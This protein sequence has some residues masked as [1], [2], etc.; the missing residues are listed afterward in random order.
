[1]RKML[2]VMVVFALAFN[3]L[4]ADNVRKNKTEPAPS[5]TTPQNIENNSRTEDWILYMIDSYGDGW[6]GASVDLL[7]NGTVVLDDQSV[8]GSEGTVYFSVDEGDIIETVWTSGSYDNEC[9]YGI[10]NHYG[11]LQASAGTEDNPTYEIYLIA[12]FPVL[13]FF[14]EYAEGTSNNKYLEIYNN[15][16]ADLDLSAYSLSSCSNGCDETGE[17]DYPDNVTFDA[18]TIVAAGDVYVVHH[19]DADA[20]IT[21]E[22]DQTHQYLSN[23]DDA[24]ALTLAGA[25]ADVYTIVDII[26]DMGDDPGAGWPVA[27]VDDG[28]KEHTLVRKGSVVHGNDGD[29][30]SSAGVT[31]DGSEWIVLEQNDWTNLGSHT[32]DGDG[33]CTDTEY[34]VTVDGGTYQSEVGWE[35]VNTSLEV[36]ASGGAPIVVGDGVTACL[37]DGSYG[38]LM[39]DSYGDGWNGNIIQLWTLDADGNPVEQFSGT[40]ESGDYGVGQFN[41]GDGPFDVLVGCTDPT[42]S[43]TDADAIW[44]DGS[45]SY[46]GTDCST[47]L[48]AAVGSN[49]ASG[50]PMWY[51]YTA[52]MSGVATVSSVGGGVDTQVYG[53]SGTCDALEQ[54]GFGDDEGGSPE[55]SSIMSFVIAEGT[56][57]YINWTDYWSSDGFVW[58]LEEAGIPTTPENL[59][60]LG[61][62][63][64][65]YLEFSPFNPANLTQ[66]AMASG[67]D[68][69]LS[70]E[71]HVQM[72]ADKVAASKVE[73]SNAWQGKTLE[74]VQDHVATLDL[75]Q[76]R[77]TETYITL[78]DSYGDGHDGD[79]YLM[80]ED[81]DGTADITF[82]ET[83]Y[84]IVETMAGGWT[85]YESAYGPFTL[86]D[87]LYYVA[88]SPDASYLGEQSYIATDAAGV[89]LGA[90]EYG[91]GDPLCFEAGDSGVECPAAAI[92]DLTFVDAD[93]D[94]I[95]GTYDAWTGRFTVEVANIGTANS[96]YFYTMAHSAYPDTT[97]LY[98]P[99][100]FQYM[101][102]GNGLEAN[103]TAMNYLSTYLTVPDLAGGY[104]DAEWTFYVMVDSYGDYCVEPGGQY[105]NVMQLPTITN[106]SPLANSNWN[107]YRGVDGGDAS[108]LTNLTA[109]N[110]VPP[111]TI[112]YTD[113]AATAESDYCYTVTQVNSTVE[114]GA[115]NQACAYSALPPEVPAPTNLSGS[116]SGFDVTLA[117][118]APEPYEGAGSWG[119]GTGV[120]SRTR[121]GGNTIEDATVLT[122]LTELATGTT[123]GYDD[124]YD[125]V[126]PYEG[127]GATDVVYS[128]TP[129]T[130]MAVNMSTCYSSYDTKLY[131]YADANG[132]LAPTTSGDPACSDDTTHPINTDCTAW[133]SYIEGVSMAAGTTYYIVIDGWGS[134]AGDYEIEFTPYNPLAGYTILTADG[135][136]GT[137]GRNA[138][139]WNTVLFAAEP[140]DLALSVRA[141]YAIPGIFDIVSSDVVGPVTVTVQI[142]DNPSDLMAMDYGDDVHLMWEP[143]IDASNMDLA[144]HDG[145]QGNATYYAGAAAVRYRVQ[146]S[147]AMKGTAQGIWMDSWPDA[148]YGDAQWR[149][150]VVTPDPDTDMPDMDNILYDN[151]EV[152]VDADP[153]SETYGWAMTSF[154]PIPVT[155]DVFV[156]YSGFYNWETASYNTPIEGV[157][158][159]DMMQCDPTMEFPASNYHIPGDPFNPDDQGLWEMG[160]FFTF[161]GDW[162][163]NV[164]ADFSVG[165]GAMLTNWIGAD[166]YASRNFTHAGDVEHANTKVNPAEYNAPSTPSPYEAQNTR[167]MLG[168]NVYRASEG[169][170]AEVVGMAEETEY[171][172][173]GL[174]WGTYTYHV[175]TLFDDH[176]SLPTNEVTV[177]L[178]NV[179]PNP[180]TIIS[181]SDGLEI[182]VTPDNLDEEVAFI[183]TAASDDDNDNLEYLMSLADPDT[184][185]WAL[186]PDNAVMNG[187]FDEYTALDNG[188]Q[189]HADGWETY[190]DG[191]HYSVHL[192]G[193]T[194]GFSDQVVNTY[195]G[196]ACV[197]LWGSGGENNL[198]QTYYEGA[199]PPGTNWWADAMVMIPTGDMMDEAGHFVLFAKYFTAD[200]GWIGM[201]SSMHV[202]PAHGLDEWMYVEVDGTVPEGT[203]T[204]Q[205]GMFLVGAEGTGSVYVDDFYAHVPLTQTGLFVSYGDIAMVAM[206]DSVNTMMIEW[207]VWSFDG[208]EATPSSGGSRM[209]TLNIS[210]ELVGVDGGIALPTE[211]ALHNNYPNPFNPVTNITYDIAQNS[212]VTLEIYNVMGQRVRTLAQGSHEPGRYRVMWNATNDYGQ[213]LSSGMYIYRIQAGDF[214]SVKK[215]ILM[216]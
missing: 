110:W 115:S 169:G 127:G 105:N 133:T 82:G 144:Y 177:T 155:G 16:G 89:Q 57:Y 211:F 61:G 162:Q 58:T 28:T 95:V 197:K 27:G 195:D 194:A 78:Y 53:Y 80:I 41:V 128:F 5:I 196:E 100:Y 139:E 93:G 37:A 198:F 22:G 212:E 167:D 97:N 192:D 170:T 31:E 215:L 189:R 124:S 87:G 56:T 138:T 121:Q 25:T 174:D 48:T 106:T 3:F 94:G 210:E 112:L 69:T 23:G 203:E 154:D 4:A 76:N 20:A 42:A 146:G 108:L 187:S 205:I 136:V 131:V 150:T 161:C 15:T 59:T 119:M 74:E 132:T 34:I 19:P 43:N 52:T 11:E 152:S 181:P 96:N 191:D 208:F 179:A 102:N 6:N 204:V 156:I 188:W 163:M 49:E 14:S 125:E 120:S 30:A 214:V 12:S 134:S 147:W 109:P 2:S 36:V 65:V 202:M 8:T 148:N 209:M 137:A 66:G 33:G 117:W 35:I 26:G 123:A 51:T 64:R 67:V 73:N 50:A 79:A 151:Q 213:S 7:V 199:V 118:D 101:W 9:A 153:T 173:E 193:E 130:D 24:Y 158:D 99:T 70:V 81:T 159:L 107:I 29:W 175:T 142:E 92:A 60:A 122:D 32:M 172:D 135:P 145:I 126:C 45:C 47:A 183:W 103:S 90:G 180:V 54:V 44:D 113:E 10:Y 171:W 166:G 17:F 84:D 40:I 140:T 88:W 143:P 186:L 83:G 157:F 111:L 160:Q 86:A 75:P 164:H 201:D 55:W 85:G 91:V 77:D 190:P 114:S 116:S 182:D 68:A 72:R 176:E 149:I 168:F 184:G 21:A 104:D 165:G 39:Y 71:E 207:D 1:M 178:S 13:V 18:G 38:I 62:L 141:D 46:E 216:K 185:I 206:E 200:W 98:P 63:G 129:A